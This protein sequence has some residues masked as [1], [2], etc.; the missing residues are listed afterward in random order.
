MKKEADANRP[1]G[2]LSVEGFVLS[3]RIMQRDSISEKDSE[4]KD[5]KSRHLHV[6]KPVCLVANVV[7][8]VQDELTFV[9][10]DPE[11]DFRITVQDSKGNPVPRTPYGERVLERQTSRHNDYGTFG[12]RV[13]PGESLQY[14]FDLGQQLDLSHAGK[15]SVQVS[16]EVPKKQWDGIADLKSNVVSFE[17]E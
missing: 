6:G 2:G 8:V 12:R 16:C 13:S 4:P 7:N 15:Y 10:A 9:H 17:L 11:R 14:E 1:A 3:I 5:Q